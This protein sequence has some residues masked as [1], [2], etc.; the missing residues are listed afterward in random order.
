M[1]ETRSLNNNTTAGRGVF[2]YLAEEHRALLRAAGT[3]LEL[4]LAP[5]LE[6]GT[7]YNVA[8]V[9]RWSE[10]K[11]AFVVG[12]HFDGLGLCGQ[13][14]YPSAYDNASGTV[15]ML[16]TARALAGAELKNDVI[17]VAFN[18]EESKFDGAEA[19]RDQVLDRYEQVNLI[20]LDCVGHKDSTI[21]TVFDNYGV[22][23]P[24]KEALLAE[25]G[26]AG[27]GGPYISGDHMSFQVPAVFVSDSDN[28]AL[29]LLAPLHCTGDVP[30]LID[31]GRLR[32]LAGAVAALVRADTLYGRDEALA[33]GGADE[34]TGLMPDELARYNALIADGTLSAYE[35][36]YVYAADGEGSLALT[37]S[38][39]QLLSAAELERAYPGM[40]LPETVGDYRLE[41]IE[42]V[43]E[44]SGSD[45]FRIY[46]Y[47]VR[48][49]EEREVGET[50]SLAERLTPRLLWAFYYAPDGRGI[51]V[52]IAAAPE[53]IHEVYEDG[54]AADAAL[55]GVWLAHEVNPEYGIDGYWRL[56]LPQ[57]GGGQSMWACTTG[58][59]GPAMRRAGRSL[60]SLRECAS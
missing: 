16:E 34:R 19:F 44:L 27:A 1:E 49:P 59:T 17:F 25:L 53:N 31:C 50:V 6:V 46:S 40:I 11:S 4:S 7:A 18:G 60:T 10:G 23:A 9:L 42:L 36:A 5:C 47:K 30:E 12:G 33:S 37:G 51:G 55:E 56:C 26:A 48:L 41:N 3:E 57:P 24:L 28:R 52:C 22:N 21:H 54:G 14:L 29:T 15:A 39:K 32:E 58:R 20:N 45:P 38:G 2:L 35:Q 8:A 13:R 43:S